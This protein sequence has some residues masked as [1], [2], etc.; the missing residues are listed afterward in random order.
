MW[1]EKKIKWTEYSKEHPHCTVIFVQLKYQPTWTR[2][3]WKNAELPLCYLLFVPDNDKGQGQLYTA[4][5]SKKGVPV[6][7]KV[8]S[9]H[10]AQDVWDTGGWGSPFRLIMDMLWTAERGSNL[11][12]MSTYGERSRYL[13][14]KMCC[15]GEWRTLWT[16]VQFTGLRFSA[17]RTTYGWYSGTV[18]RQRQILWFNDTMKVIIQ[19]NCGLKNIRNALFYLHLH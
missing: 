12:V 19:G 7:F 13:Y 14:S 6:L 9:H 4:L 15:A 18:H 1:G 2:I 5:T 16:K 10:L 17:W 11:N 3:T 8:T